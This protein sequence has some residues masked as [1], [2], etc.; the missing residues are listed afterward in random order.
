LRR[1]EALQ[2][3]VTDRLVT[4]PRAKAL[5]DAE[6]NVGL[7]ESHTQLAQS[8]VDV[9]F[10]ESRLTP[11]LLQNGLKL[12]RYLVEHEYFESSPAPR[13]DYSPKSR[14]S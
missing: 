12:A 2:N 1:G 11:E 7:E 5:G 4:H 14:K 10:G 13:A 3:L 6:V 9:G 8:F